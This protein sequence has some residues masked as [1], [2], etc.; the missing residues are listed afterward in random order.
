MPAELPDYTHEGRTDDAGARR[1]S[2]RISGL[3]SKRSH[4]Q[5]RDG[6]YFPAS[7]RKD[8]ALQL[9]RVLSGRP[10]GPRHPAGRPDKTLPSCSA[11]SFRAD[12][13]KY[14]P[15][16]R[17][18]WERFEQSPEILAEVL[19]APASSVRPSWV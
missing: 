2:A 3:C 10:G 7:A 19:R 17:W 11:S 4:G 15:S 12:A 5:R 8:D 6:A 13:G 18:P 9:G 16:R 14:A 1:T